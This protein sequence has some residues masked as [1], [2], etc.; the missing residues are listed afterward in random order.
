MTVTIAASPPGRDPAT[1]FSDCKVSQVTSVTPG[2]LEFRVGKSDGTGHEPE[3]II[4]IPPGAA[5]MLQ[6]PQPA[7]LAIKGLTVGD[8]V[9]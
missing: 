6:Y 3:H 9:E 1:A 2:A 4:A 5:I 7:W 8:T